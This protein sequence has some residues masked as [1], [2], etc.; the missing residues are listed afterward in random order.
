M[1]PQLDYEVFFSFM[2]EAH[3]VWLVFWTILGF[4][5]IYSLFLLY[6]WF[7]YGLNSFAIW[8]VMILYFSVSFLLVGVMFLSVMNIV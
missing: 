4:A 8:V 7:R 6:H 5:G 2:Y 1:V 3:I